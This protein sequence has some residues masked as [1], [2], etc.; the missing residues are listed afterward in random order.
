MT[1]TADRIDEAPS[2]AERYSRAANSSDLKM[3]E[4]RC[5]LDYMVASGWVGDRLGTM[6]YRLR[7][8]FDRVHAEVRP[9]KALNHAERV[10][11]LSRLPSLGA[12]KQAVGNMAVVLATRR[13]FMRPDAAALILA[14]RAL[15]VFLYPLCGHCDGRG[16][17]G[18][19]RHEDSGP[20]VLCRPCG[21]SGRRRNT[22]GRDDNE[23]K[24][25]ALLLS[26]LER[27]TSSVEVEMAAF[28]HN[29]ND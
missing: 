22:I 18:G 14:G 7:G 26:E 19:G 8:E 11:V 9:G 10:L 24:F 5:D 13:R 21:G 29:R 20:Q 17:T 1:Q 25:G 4:G 3:R 28:L 12:T 15:D 27:L 23:A 16:F 2:L 6:L